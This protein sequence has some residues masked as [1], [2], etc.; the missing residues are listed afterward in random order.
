MKISSTSALVLKWSDTSVYK[1]A[2]AVSFLSGLD[3][4]AADEI[5]RRMDEESNRMHTEA[6]SNRKRFFWKETSDFLEACAASGKTG[7]VVILAAGISPLSI[8]LADRF[9]GSRVWDIDLYL[10]EEKAAL[11]GEALPNLRFITADITDIPD[12]RSQLI[13]TD[14]DPDRPSIFVLEGIN[15]YISTD[16]LFE[17]LHW[18]NGLGAMA[19]GDFVLPPSVV[20]A[21]T[22]RFPKEVFDVVREVAGLDFIQFYRRPEFIRLLETAGYKDIRFT[23]LKSVQEERTGSPDPFREAGTEWIELWTAR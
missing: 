22:R 5:L 2:A 1:S 8:D 3:F 11:V 6:V 10:M 9:P 7:Q 16:D 18:V 13:A 4:S 20:H 14:F 21:S 19:C 23:A 15:Y 12:W 17:I